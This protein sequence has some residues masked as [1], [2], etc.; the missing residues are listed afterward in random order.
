M[1]S[2]R[3]QNRAEG[4]SDVALKHSPVFLLLSRLHGLRL[5]GWHGLPGGAN[6][7]CLAQPILGGGP[8]ERLLNLNFP[9]EIVRVFGQIRGG[10]RWQPTLVCPAGILSLRS[11]GGRIAANPRYNNKS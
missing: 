7:C 1:A 5:W 2:A 10:E 3:M 9:D 4:T 8:E 11:S 6:A